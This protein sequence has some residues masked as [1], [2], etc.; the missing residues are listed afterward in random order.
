M[1]SAESFVILCLGAFSTAAQVLLFRELVSIFTGFELCLGVMFGCWFVGIAFGA[2]LA[3]RIL[4]FRKASGAALLFAGLAL[5][6]ALPAL[7]SLASISRSWL[8]QQPGLLPSLSDV[9][10]GAL[11]LVTPLGWL[12]GLSFPLACGVVRQGASS[13][14]VAQVYVLESAG[15]IAGGVGVGWALA[16]QRGPLSIAVLFSLPL[17]LGLGW[18]GWPRNAGTRLSRLAAGYSLALALVAGLALGG[19][20]V[21]GWDRAM[22]RARFDQLGAGADLMLSLDTPYHHLDL[23]RRQDQLTVFSDGQVGMSFP[24]PYRAR[25]RAHLVLSEHPAPGKVLFLGNFSFELLPAAMRHPLERLDLVEQDLGAFAPIQ[26]HLD[27]ETRGALGNARVRL[28]WT[29]GRR[30]LRTD[31]GTWDLIFSDAPDPFTVAANRFFTLEFFRLV[32]SRLR[33]GGVFVGRH[34]SS[35]SYL[36]ADTATLIRTLRQTLSQVFRHVVVL[37]GEETTLVASDEAAAILDSPEALRARY[38][39]RQVSDP[40][41]SPL[42][43]ATLF[44]AQQV[45]DLRLQLDERGSAGIN[46]DSQPLIH[47]Q[48]AIRW[49]RMIGDRQALLWSRLISWPFWAWLALGGLLLGWRFFRVLRAPDRNTSAVRLSA[50]CIALSGG[51]GLALEL[52]LSFDYQS[53]VGTLYQELCWIIA[54]FMGGLVLGGVLAQHKLRRAEATPQ[55]LGK[56]MALFA[57]FL[58]TLPWLLAHP[59]AG[60]SP[61]L[62]EISA[63]L[64]QN[65]L[66][67]GFVGWVF[68]MGSGLAVHSGQEVLSAAGK[69]D[70]ADHLGAC[71]GALLT[72]VIW[73][74]GLGRG[75]T[76]FLLASLA[77]LMGCLGLAMGKRGDLR[78]FFRIPG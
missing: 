36:G 56:A 2:A 52:L 72:G 45:R 48:G 43:F 49:G 25:P 62:L 28:H 41:F 6:H 55:G 57:V 21:E 15:A 46:Q 44:Q 10:L 40:R 64:L 26:A 39:Q 50:S 18:L 76:C 5:V 75:P 23:A 19:H 32:R 38:E 22:A 69:L 31:P 24:D 13:Q 70:A 65:A 3:P 1:K 58:G 61:L 71:A 67:G 12:I 20:W 59:L 74:P 54:S 11:F 37:P 68:A 35:A 53:R 17:L 4:A 77:L 14:T 30:F 9:F 33:S 16:G 51:L 73:L 34:S 78:A 27:E 8:T 42:Q 66:G 29:D 63:L 47:A 60:S 7:M